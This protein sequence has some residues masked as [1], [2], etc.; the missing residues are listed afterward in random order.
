MAAQ[1]WPIDFAHSSVQFTV[2]HMIVSKVRG[3]FKRWE[4]SLKLDEADLSK[5]SVAVSIDAASIDTN[6]DKRDGHLRSADFLDVETYPKITFKSAK[7]TTKGEAELAVAGDLTIRGITKPVTLVVE[8]LG[9]AKD[10]WGNEKLLFNGK[11]AIPREEYGASWRPG[12]RR[13]GGVLVGKV[14]DVDIELQAL[15]PKG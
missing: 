15:V 13:A 4:A 7:I 1:E 8:R 6:D 14:V 12:P 3:R 10:P 11:I 2:R 9:R 5:S